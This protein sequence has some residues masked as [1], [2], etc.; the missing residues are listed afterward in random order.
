MT[1]MPAM[2]APCRLRRPGSCCTAA[3]ASLTSARRWAP[4]SAS[5]L[6]RSRARSA[7]AMSISSASSAISA[8]TESLLSAKERKPP[9]TA[10]TTVPPSVVRTVTGP[11]WSTPST[12]SCDG[13]MPMSPDMVRAMTM[14][15]SPDQMLRSAATT[16]T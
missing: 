4:A 15:A 6:E 2:P 12:G 14:V 10:A 11:D 5:D 1:A 16:S 13:M 3:A 8:R 9:C 7:R